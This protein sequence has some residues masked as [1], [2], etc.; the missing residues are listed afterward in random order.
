MNDVPDHTTGVFPVQ[1]NDPYQYDR[2]PNSIAEQSLTYT[3][4]ATPE[5]Q[6]SPTRMGGESGVMNTGIVVQRARRRRRRGAGGGR[7]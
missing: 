2:N 1:S 3:L 4:D 7:S 5:V 6:T